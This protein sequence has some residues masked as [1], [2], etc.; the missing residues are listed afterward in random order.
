MLFFKEDSVEK[1]DRIEDDSSLVFHLRNKGL[2]ILTG[3]AHAGII[4]TIT[5]ARE[6][7]GIERIH[8]V[9]GGFHLSGGCATATAPTIAALKKL[10]P[11]YVIP[12][13]CTGRDATLTIEKEM[14]EQF[15]L[16]M[17]GTRFSFC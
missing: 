11:D 9:M 7:T 15:L 8:A 3:C 14:A 1:K 13:H 6:I 12:A 5:H 17:S 10:A 4:N 16:N 2:V